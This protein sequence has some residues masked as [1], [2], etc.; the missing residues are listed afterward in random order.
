MKTPRFLVAA[1][2]SLALAFTFSCSSNSSDDPT[3]IQSSSSNDG[4]SSSSVGGQGGISSDGGSS[5]SGSSSSSSPVDEISS[6][7]EELSSSSLA[8]SSSVEPSSSSL[9]VSVP[10]GNVSTGAGTVSCGEQTYNTVQIG[11]QVWMK[12]N[13][14][15]D[16]LDN[17]TDVCY[18]NDPDNCDTYG[19]LYNWATAMGLPS[20]CNSVSCSS[21]ID[22]PHQGICP[23]GWHLPSDDEWYTLVNYVQSQ[24]D[25][26]VS[27]AGTML[28]A[29]SSLWYEN[30]GIDEY[31]FSAL[32]GGYGVGTSFNGV[33]NAGNWWSSTN[34]E[35]LVMSNRAY[36]RNIGY[37]GSKSVDRLSD[38]KTY[39]FSVRCVQ[40]VR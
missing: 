22:S 40:D 21:Q 19:R 35:S 26:I 7:S 37:Y 38:S 20:N 16:V 6:S 1:C 13:L 12:E 23:S 32:P 28:K 3:P 2:I 14:N 9:F 27:C 17:D 18:D 30:T 24:V 8:S 39:L 10:C 33:G 31:E 29:N 25:C 5:S 34:V 11:D 15:Y 36:Y 4:G